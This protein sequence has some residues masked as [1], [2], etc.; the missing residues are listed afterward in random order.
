MRRGRKLRF[1]RSFVGVQGGGGRLCTLPGVS[2]WWCS[3]AAGSGP[4]GSVVGAAA[5][6]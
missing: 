3:S 4:G 5:A 1:L 6:A 2:L